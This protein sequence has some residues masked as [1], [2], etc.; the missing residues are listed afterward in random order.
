V[1]GIARSI[2]H[3][4]IVQG[5]IKSNHELVFKADCRA[6]SGE[7]RL[8]TLGRDSDLD[9]GLGRLGDA[10]RFVDA[11]ND[12]YAEGLIV[13]DPVVDVHRPTRGRVARADERCDDCDN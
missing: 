10:A 8:A 9:R 5:L 7:E 11:A 12:T 3:D 1:G 13:H 6:S 4:P 2:N